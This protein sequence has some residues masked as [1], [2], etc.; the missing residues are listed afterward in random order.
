M[1]SYKAVF[2]YKNDLSYKGIIGV[3]A[4]SKELATKLVNLLISYNSP[5]LPQNYDRFEVKEDI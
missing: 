3:Q 1:K 4:D 2:Y 5:D